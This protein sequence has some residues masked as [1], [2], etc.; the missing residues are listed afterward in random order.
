MSM[1]ATDGDERMEGIAHDFTE[2]ERPMSWTGQNWSPEE[3]RFV[4]DLT[5]DGRADIVGFGRDGVWVGVNIDGSTFSQP[6]MVLTSF[7]SQGWH[8]GQ[9]LRLVV[10]LTGDGKADIIG[11]GDHGVGTA[12]NNG[13]GT[14]ALDKPVLEEFGVDHGWRVEQHPRFVVDVT[15][16]GK[17]DIVGFGNDGVWTAL[18]NGDGTFQAPKLVLTNF[19]VKQGWR[20]EQHPRFV[21]DVTGDGKADIVGFGNDGVWTALGNGDGTFQAPKLVLEG[22]NVNQGWRVEQHPRF[23]VDLTGDGKAD[24]VG[25]GNDGVWTAVSNGDG[26]FQA[27]RLVLE[28]FNVNQGWRVEQHPRFVADLTGDRK[29]DIVGFGNDGVWTA[30]SKGDGTFGEPKFF[31]G[32]G[33]KQGWR[34]DQHL[35]LL[36]DLTGDGKADIIAFGNDDGPWVA[37]S[38]GDGTFQPAQFVR[39]DVGP[40]SAI[41][42][43]VL[44]SEFLQRK[45]DIFFNQRSRPLFKVRL[46]NLGS[47]DHRHST[48]DVLFDDPSKG[49]TSQL[50]DG[51]PKDLGQLEVSLPLAPDPDFHFSDVNSTTLA[52]NVV[53]G[54]PVGIQ[55]RIDFEVD[56]VEMIVNNF[57][58]IDFDGFNIRV[59]F[60]LEHD[61]DAG[62][63]DV[64]T[65]KGLIKTDVSVNVSGLPDGVFASGVED[66]FNGKIADALEEN[67]EFLNRM[68]TRWLVGGDFTVLGVTGDEQ[69]LTISYIIPPGQLEPFPEHPQPPL[70]PG[71]LA[72]IDH[73]VVLMMEN[74]SFDHM[75]G[76]LSKEGH[77][78]GKKRIDIDGLRGGEVNDDDRG[79]RYQ[80]FPLPDTSFNESPDHSHLPVENQING[81]KMDGFVKSFIGKYPTV[82]SPGR[83]MGYH[84]A[85]HVPVYDA[86]AREF[87][88]C[89]RWFAAH[90]GPTFCNRFY[91]LTGRLNRDSFGNFQFDNFTG[92]EFKPVPTKTIFHHLTDH[93]VSWHFYEHRYCSLRMYE[94]Y[95]LDDHY[96]VDADDPVK[97]FFACA[98]A[99]TLPAVSFIDPNF[100]DEPDGGDNDDGAPANITA[101]QNLIG[102]VINAVLGGPNWQKTLL[103]VTYDEHGGFYDHVNPLDPRYRTNAKPVSG[104]DHYGVRVPALIISPW[105]DQGTV[106]DVVFDHTSIAKTI[107]RRFMSA[108]PPDLGERVAAAN[109]I[110]MVLRATPRQDTPSIPVPPAPAPRSAFKKRAALAPDRDDFKE[111]MRTLRD[112]YPIR[113]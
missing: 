65:D 41:K 75:L 48:V 19:G 22:F 67:R 49:Y 28:G 47:G 44:S 27:P 5:G 51:Q 15:G 102:R 69:A 37:L 42:K 64:R 3:L 14:F 24:I 79:H 92:S 100:I 83:I 17:A 111:I 113:R 23:V 104:I 53:P 97:G 90:P 77:G 8:R 54:S 81:G 55:V 99:G 86:V 78:N 30:L 89:H 80:S 76:Y 25:F 39:E 34:V 108:N 35:R 32:F 94:Q 29:A 68:A 26:T 60:R 87:L 106:S 84:T 20:V 66:K 2:E 9:H 62:L 70:D 43:K 63:V 93:A 52:A 57:P 6:H 56:G 103:I 13:D 88:I 16:D 59:G 95:T 107:A 46:H 50:R 45:L 10:D 11:F 96:I 82:D 1:F 105:V 91:T 61:R 85:S 40:P 72:N 109:D 38:N 110:S 73:I 36:A 18:G 112:R 33:V 101:G 7:N 74:R 98:Q 21:V 12:V 4:T 31:E 58:D 71:R